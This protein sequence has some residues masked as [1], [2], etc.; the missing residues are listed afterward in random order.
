MNRAQFVH[1]IAL[2]GPSGSGKTTLLRHFIGLLAPASGSVRV[3]GRLVQKDPLSARRRVGMV[4]QKP[5]PFPKS[6]YDNSC[7]TLK[8]KFG[9]D[10]SQI[11]LNSSHSHNTPVLRGALLDV[12]PLDE[13]QREKIEE[14]LGV[15]E[16]SLSDSLV[17]ANSVTIA[18]DGT[19]YFT[20]SS[21]KFGASRFA[22]SY[23][24]SLLDIMEH[25]G[26]SQNIFIII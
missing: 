7:A 11:M 13:Q 5:N 10:R 12:Y 19:I 20:E 24:A 23:K 1:V 6:I 25:G 4:F 9:L 18:S 21:R 22:G 15:F 14:Y 8:E 3:G 26:H 16:L 2:I 17:A